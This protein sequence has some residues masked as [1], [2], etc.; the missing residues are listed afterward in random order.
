MNGMVQPSSSNCRVLST[1]RSARF[2]ASDILL[3]NLFMLY[4]L[5]LCAAKVHFFMI[6]ELKVSKKYCHG[7]ACSTKMPIFVT[8]N[9]G[10]VYRLRPLWPLRT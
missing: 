5:F 1:P 2:N 6:N 3:A 8:V 9:K 7:G 4:V 10:E